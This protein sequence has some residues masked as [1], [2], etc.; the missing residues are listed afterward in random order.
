M[1]RILLMLINV[2]VLGTSFGQVAKPLQ[3]RE[4]SYDFGSVKEEGGAVMH[5]FLFTNNS[6]R[7]VKILTVQASCGCTTPSWTKDPVAPGKTGFIQASF[8]PKGRPGYFNKS[9]TITTDFDSNPLIL[10]IKGQVA[11]DG[12][13]AAA[14][15][16]FQAVNGNWKLKSGS[17]NMG[18]VYMKDEFTVRDFQVLNS[19]SKPIN[20]SGKFTGPSHIKVDVLPR[21]L[22][23]GEKGH[24][25]VSYNGKLKGL[26]GFQSDNIEI[27]TDDELNPAKSFSVYATL[28]DNFKDL[29]PEDIAKAPHLQLQASTLDF[30]K[31]RPN[32]T[33]VREVQFSNT[34]KRELQ[35]RSVQGNCT[36][37]T[38]SSKAVSLKPGESS[39]LKIEFNPMERKGTQQKAVTVYSNDPQSPVQRLTF[40]AYV[41]D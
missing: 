34:G 12:S 39:T 17:F 18:K 20:Y 31:I 24:I 25:K 36:C 32:A 9:L 28:E 29:K 11:T 7:P 8:N 5:E 41:E 27:Q 13:G 26:Y 40:T 37:I 35:I 23:P 15:A 14:N 6:G 1:N 33:T 10:Q 21:T 3:F 38:A 30:G 22:A 4:E 2:L 19:G 16:E